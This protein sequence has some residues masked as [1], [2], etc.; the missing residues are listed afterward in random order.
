MESYGIAIL[1]LVVALVV[2]TVVLGIWVWARGRR[3]AELQLAHGT[4]AMELE[5]LRR[6]VGLDAEEERL[7]GLSHEE[8]LEEL[9]S[10][11]A[12][13]DAGGDAGPR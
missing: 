10:Y 4:M 7:E 5:R 8:R 3:V 6:A 12:G 9:N 11:L 13:G 1:V 2:V